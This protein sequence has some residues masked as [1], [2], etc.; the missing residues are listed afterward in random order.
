MRIEKDTK[1]EKNQSQVDL[2]LELSVG[3]GNLFLVKEPT[4]FSNCSSFSLI[5]Q[6]FLE[7][8]ATPMQINICFSLLHFR[9]GKFFP[10]F[11]K[12]DSLVALRQALF[13]F[14]DFRFCFLSSFHF[15]IYSFYVIILRNAFLQPDT[16]T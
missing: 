1:Q 7:E 8:S 5:F 4:S 15:L 6:F 12:D 3:R 10:L 9:W 2:I 16:C 14:N 13:L 11:S